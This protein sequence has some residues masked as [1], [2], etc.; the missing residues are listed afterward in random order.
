MLYIDKVCQDSAVR[1]ATSYG[2]D[3]REVVDRF[4]GG[5]ETIYFLLTFT[6]LTIQWV[7]GTLSPGVKRPQREADH[8]P[9]PNA[10]VKEYVK[11]YFC[12]TIRF[13]VIQ[14]NVRNQIRT[15]EIAVSTCIPSMAL[16]EVIQQFTSLVSEKQ[17]RRFL[18]EVRLCRYSP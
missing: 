1:A 16:C 4:L 10:E 18:K 14:S 11:L 17:T 7:A 15:C 13:H 6:Q 9:S 12:S 2:P 3:D 8:S 5:G